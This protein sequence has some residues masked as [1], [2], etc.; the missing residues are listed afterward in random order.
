MEDTFLSP[1][2]WVP[3]IEYYNE[4]VSEKNGTIHSIKEKLVLVQ[5]LSYKLSSFA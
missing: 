4:F 3:L 2:C 5:A 1:V